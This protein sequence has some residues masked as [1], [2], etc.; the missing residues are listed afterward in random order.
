MSRWELTREIETLAA[1]IGL[2]DGAPVDRIL[3]YCRQRIDTWVDQSGGVESVEALESLVTRQLQMVF[4][5]IHSDDDWDRLT[6]VYARGKKEFV[7][8]GMRTKFDDEN[9]PTYGALVQRR[10]AGDDDPDRFVAVI[11]CRE[12]KLARRFFTRW[13]EIAHRLTTHADMLEP[14]YRSEQD[15]IE[16]LMDEIAGQVGFYEPLFNPAFQKAMHG[17]RHL[18]FGGIESVIENAFPAASFQATLF[19]CFRRIETPVVYLEATLGHK[20]E[21]R[22]KLAT[23]SLF[24]DATPSGELRAVKVLQNKA[25]QNAR[26]TIPTN[27][28]VPVGSLIHRLF[29]AEPQADGSA[30]EDLNHWESQG[31][32]LEACPV[33]VEARKVPDRVIAT[34]QPLNFGRKVP[35]G[36]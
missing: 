15:P 14:A 4:E 31:R 9:D 11:D 13:H 23:P 8:A 16:R 36:R 20:K 2:G 1:E 33:V 28:R 10:N 24:N 21:V 5:E 30:Q 29:D 27:M 26:F 35:H 34:V 32:S 19:A 18:T 17:Q 12:S 6:D 22:R 3:N 7:F 25:A